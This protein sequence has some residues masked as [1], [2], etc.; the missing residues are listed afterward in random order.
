MEGVE[1]AS[2]REAGVVSIV[3]VVGRR[4]KS[5]K[6]RGEENQ[7]RYWRSGADAAEDS[8]HETTR[9]LEEGALHGWFCGLCLLRLVLIRWVGF[10]VAG[11]PGYYFR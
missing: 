1:R 11:V 5:C 8:S 7:G 9:M 2:G 6:G 10:C 4:C 3:R